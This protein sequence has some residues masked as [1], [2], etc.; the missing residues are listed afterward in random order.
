MCCLPLNMRIQPIPS[1]HSHFS[2]SRVE[3]ENILP[4][5]SIQS[6]RCQIITAF[7]HLGFP[8]DF[9][10]PSQ[11]MIS[12]SGCCIVRFL[13]VCFLCSI[14]PFPPITSSLSVITLA[15]QHCSKYVYIP[16]SLIFH[17]T[18][19][20]RLKNTDF[21]NRTD[22]NIENKQKFLTG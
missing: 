1:I 4:T 13:A 2:I 12:Q 5:M 8:W 9:S 22:T 15:C 18:E 6:S 10:Q 3:N 7:A 11:L 16:G 14:K 19:L 17:F 20:S 21:P